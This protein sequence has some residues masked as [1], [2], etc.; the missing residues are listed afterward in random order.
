MDKTSIIILNWNSADDTIECIK[1]LEKVKGNFEVILLDNGSKNEDFIKLKKLKTNLKLKL[2][3]EK[4][5]TGFARGNNIAIKHADKNSTYYCLLNND[6]IVESNFLVKLLETIKKNDM[7]AAVSPKIMYY[8]NPK[9]IWAAGS[10]F[11]EFTGRATLRCFNQKDFS[12]GEK[13]VSALVGCCMLI[14]KHV[15]IKTKGFGEKYFAYIEETDWCFRTKKLGF[16]LFLQPHSVIYH[17][18]GMS[19]GGGYSPRSIFLLVR[20]KRYFIAKNSHGLQF[21][22]WGFFY[23]IEVIARLLLYNI[24]DFEKSMKVVQAIF[25]S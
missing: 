19:T 9:I 10:T 17:K 16:K 8:S 4:Q 1:S 6:T 20:N 22:L 5:N 7:I 13:E 3:R 18:V 24:I 11:N 25:S 14:R 15:W 21:I 12:E 23:F 2:F